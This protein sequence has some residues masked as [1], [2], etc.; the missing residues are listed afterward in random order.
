MGRKGKC[1]AEEDVKLQKTAEMAKDKSEDK[2]EDK[3]AD[4]TEDKPEDSAKDK[5]EERSFV[6]CLS[7]YFCDAASFERTDLAAYRAHLVAEHGVTRN[8]E[9]LLHLA[10]QLQAEQKSVE[11]KAEDELAE[12]DIAIIPEVEDDVISSTNDIMITSI[13]DN[14]ESNKKAAAAKNNTSAPKNKRADCQP[15]DATKDNVDEAEKKSDESVEIRGTKGKQQEAQPESTELKVSR[16]PSPQTAML[17]EGWEDPARQKKA[18]KQRNKKKESNQNTICDQNKLDKAG[19]ETTTHTEDL[20]VNAGKLEEEPKG[21]EAS[22]GTKNQCKEQENNPK[23]PDLPKKTENQTKVQEDKPKE[24]KR[25]GET[26]NQAKDKDDQPK[27]PEGSPGTEDQSNKQ[28][29]K[30]KGKQNKPK[31]LQTKSKSPKEKVSGPLVNSKV[32]ESQTKGLDVEKPSE[33][34]DKLKVPEDNTKELGDDPKELKDKTHNNK[35]KGLAGKDKTKA[36]GSEDMVTEGK[37]F[38]QE[39]EDQSKD[40]KAKQKELQAG[41]QKSHKQM[42]LAKEVEPKSEAQLSKGEEIVEE[43]E[44]KTLDASKG[45]SSREPNEISNSKTF[46][47]SPDQ[48][49][50]QRQAKVGL[51][52]Q[53]TFSQSSLPNIEQGAGSGIMERTDLDEVNDLLDEWFRGEGAD[54]DVPDELPDI[55]GELGLPP[56]PKEPLHPAGA[57]VAPAPEPSRRQKDPQDLPCGDCLVCGQLAKALCSGCKHVFYCSRDHQKKDWSAHKDN[58]KELSKLPWRVERSPFLGRFLTATR[59]LE[60]GQLILQDTPLVVGPRQLT[61]PVCLGCHKEISATD[62]KKCVRCNWPVCSTRCQDSVLHVPECRATQAAG[63]KIKVEVFGQVNMMYA[64]ITVLRALALQEGP[65]KVW[66]DYT[67]FD[68]H[69]SERIKTPVYSKVNKEKVVFF[70]HH[71]LGIQRYSDLEILEACGKLDTNCF[72][73]RQGG[74]NLRAMYRTACLISHDCSPNTRHTFAP[75][76]TIHIYTTR[77]INKGDPISATYTNSL[78]CT[79]DRRQHLNVSKCFWCECDRCF[80]PTEFGSYLS[81]IRCSRCSGFRDHIQSDDLQYITSTNPLDSEALWKCGKCTNIQK[82]NQIRAGNLAVGKELKEVNRSSVE[83]L[84]AVLSKYESMLGP[85]NHHIVDVKYSIASLLGNRPAY[86]L[87]IL[88]MEQLQ[89]KEKYCRE[90]L[91]LADKV[92]PG[93]TRWRGQLLLELQMAVVALAAGQAQAGLVGKARAKEMAQEALDLLKQATAILQ[94]EPDMISILAERMSTISSLLGQWEE[95]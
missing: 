62:H 37:I 28:K 67:K 46:K 30:Q 29:D 14:N 75:D 76:H 42:K 85:T 47:E 36:K 69:L 20:K 50:D 18:K 73:I 23:E 87:D 94:V 51:D 77:R 33:P 21:P 54:E 60:E 71:Y 8:L 9:A 4:K 12:D 92:E 15:L 5:A 44:Q 74:L 93:S 39:A 57:P 64:C 81:A 13:D 24:P 83:S 78:W 63:S 40:L 25:P 56:A 68:S 95:D 3:T 89:L 17:Q 22:Q 10:T 7:C 72:E 80:D 65:R 38:S 26:E 48:S 6:C 91:Q 32:Q 52:I 1:K 88:S 55:G 49:G 84:L 35:S 82:A 16:E 59:D 31:E 19:D 90:L 66:E 34:A 79:E 41:G 45:G 58:C 86:Q 70:I 61:K 53:D 2:T 27:G 11:E 43:A